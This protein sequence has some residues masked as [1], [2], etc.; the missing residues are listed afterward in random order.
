MPRDN[1]YE[2][3]TNRRIA[4][5]ALAGCAGGI[6]LAEAIVWGSNTS[7]LAIFGNAIESL[8]TGLTGAAGAT[9]LAELVYVYPDE[10]V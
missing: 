6:A 4:V 10:A 9:A 7:A 3:S 8:A 5:W 2:A 1:S